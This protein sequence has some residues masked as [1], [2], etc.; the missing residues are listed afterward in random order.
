ME[1]GRRIGENFQIQESTND[2]YSDDNGRTTLQ[3]FF[4]ALQEN[5]LDLFEKSY[6]ALIALH[7][8]TGINGAWTPGFDYYWGEA[9]GANGDV[10]WGAYSLETGWTI[11]PIIT[12]FNWFL[13]DF[14]PFIPLDKELKQK[15]QQLYQ[16]EQ[17][18]QSDLEKNW[19]E[20]TP[21]AKKRLK[22]LTKDE[23]EENKELFRN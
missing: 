2:I 15:L 16:K 11:G 14:N 4:H 19:K 20:N 23:L 10:G 7:S 6:S 12:A 21:K 17:K 13:T 1:N 9:Y 8:P 5:D 3:S 22:D 18:I